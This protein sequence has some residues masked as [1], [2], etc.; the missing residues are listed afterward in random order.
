MAQFFP[1]KMPSSSTPGDAIERGESFVGSDRTASEERSLC[2]EDLV[3]NVLRKALER[4]PCAADLLS[5]P[6]D[7]LDECGTRQQDG[8]MYDVV[9]QPRLGPYRET[10]GEQQSIAVGQL[11]RSA[12]QGVV[13]AC[14]GFACSSFGS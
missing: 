12:E 11:D 5:G 9:G 13:G 4:S 3:D 10:A 1:M 14:T 6:Q 7:T 2:R 8:A